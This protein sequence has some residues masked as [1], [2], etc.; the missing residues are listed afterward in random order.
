MKAGYSFET[1]GRIMS[2][3]TDVERMDHASMSG[4]QLATAV[5]SW[6]NGP[7]TGP[8]AVDLYAAELKKYDAFRGMDSASLRRVVSE[9]LKERGGATLVEGKPVAEKIAY[10]RLSAGRE[11]GVDAPRVEGARSGAV[12]PPRRNRGLE[13]PNP[14]ES[15]LERARRVLNAQKTPIPR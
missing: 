12:P 5:S 4:R 11:G 2:N 3:M 15:P 13:P 8:D 10:V 7:T 14:L 1:A 9:R 6:I